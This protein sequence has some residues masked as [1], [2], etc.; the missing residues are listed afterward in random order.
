MNLTFRPFAMDDADEVS[1]MMLDLYVGDPGGAPMSLDKTRATFAALLDKPDRGNILVMERE[2]AIVGYSVLINFWSNEYGGNLLHI[3]ELYV[4][5]AYR[6][7]GIASQF[8]HYLR[9]QQFNNLVGMMLEVSDINDQARKLYYNLGF[10]QH[11][12]EVLFLRK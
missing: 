11:K 3:D 8:V 7:Q 5:A 1:A 4:K 2:G 6:S 10:K 12:N 9:E